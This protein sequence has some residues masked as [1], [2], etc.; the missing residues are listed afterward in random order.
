MRL[1]PSLE[2]KAVAD[3]T[4]KYVLLLLNDRT[5]HL[6]QPYSSNK[7]LLIE[8]QLAKKHET[9]C[10]REFERGAAK[11]HQI[12]E[13]VFS[14]VTVMNVKRTCGLTIKI[15]CL[16]LLIK[17]KNNP[18]FL[19]RSKT[20][21]KIAYKC[22]RKC[23]DALDIKISYMRSAYLFLCFPH[24]INQLFYMYMSIFSETR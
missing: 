12:R 9:F 23:I 22:S 6:V 10:T 4:K 18:T 14:F 3:Y 8:D 21:Q 2:K 1:P 13:R 24:E 15:Y 7:D 11:E 17:H 20:R 5:T 19:A 16:L